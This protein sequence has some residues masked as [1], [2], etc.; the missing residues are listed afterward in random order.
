MT[1]EE[2]KEI[3]QD[4]ID[5]L[6]YLP[7]AQLKEYESYL[8]RLTAVSVIPMEVKDGVRVYQLNKNLQ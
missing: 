7:E 1:T 5:R 2:R 4:V 3:I 8:S 6:L